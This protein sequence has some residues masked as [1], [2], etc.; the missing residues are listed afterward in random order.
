MFFPAI[1]I[2][3]GVAGLIAS[4]VIFQVGETTSAVAGPSMDKIDNIPGLS[5][6]LKM[7][8]QNL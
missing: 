3:S 5:C 2:T 7:C 4:V 1:E 6:S 8:V